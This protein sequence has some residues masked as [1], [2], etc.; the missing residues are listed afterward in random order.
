MYHVLWDNG[1]EACGALDTKFDDLFY[2]K[3]ACYMCYQG[4]MES[5]AD[6]SAKDWNWMIFSAYAYV[7]VHDE[8][9]DAYISV[10]EPSDKD[11]EDIGW[12]ERKES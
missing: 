11:L 12:V 5:M 1:V 10:W 2:A 6:A 7:A 8:E 9:V 4:W 3:Q